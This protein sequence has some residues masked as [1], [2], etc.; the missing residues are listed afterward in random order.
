MAGA[1]G[2]AGDG[3]LDQRSGVMVQVIIDEARDKKSCGYS[4]VAAAVP[5][6]LRFAAAVWRADGRSWLSMKGSAVP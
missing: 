6:E 1:G 2:R 5:A 4:L 3:A